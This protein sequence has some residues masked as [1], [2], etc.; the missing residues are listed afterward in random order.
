MTRI[1]GSHVIRTRCCGHFFSTPAYASINYSAQEYWTDG[2]MGMSLAPRTALRQCVCGACYFLGQADVVHTVYGER[3]KPPAPAGW[4]TRADNWLTRLFGRES[5][6]QVMQRYD[7]RTKEQTAAA[8]SILPEPARQV[9]DTDLKRLIAEGGHQPNVEIELRTL[10]WHCL[11]HQLR[12]VYRKFRSRYT[13]VGPDGCSLEFPGFEPTQEQLANM[14]A[15]ILALESQAEP[16]MLDLAELY[17]ELG[18]MGTARHWL[19]CHERSGQGLVG[20]GFVI[21][22]MVQSGVPCPIRYRS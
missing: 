17:R 16:R 13:K 11:N 19:D 6:V 10:Y 21:G 8:K 2:Y 5:R 18:E 7:T 20:R 9:Q 4:E 22:R 3:W 14:Q 15:L 12:E 1:V